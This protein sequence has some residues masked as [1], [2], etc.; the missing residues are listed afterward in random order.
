MKRGPI[1]ALSVTMAMATVATMGRGWIVAARSEPDYRTDVVSAERLELTV[2]ASG[3]VEPQGS[4]EIGTE[5]SGRIQKVNVRPNDRIHVGEV[6]VVM[7]TEQLESRYRESEA[8]VDTARAHVL[9]SDANLL[10][11]EARFARVTR[12]VGMGFV[13]AQELDTA[14][15]TLERSKAGVLIAKAQVKATV[16]QLR[17]AK[18]NLQK[19]TIRSPLDGVV[20]ARNVEPGQTVAAA[21]QTPF[22]LKLA[23]PLSM[24]ELHL[25]VNEA[26]LGGVREGQEAT[27]TVDAFPGKVFHSAVASLHN[28]PKSVQG[29]VVYE[30]IMDAPNEQLELRPGMTATARIKTS[31]LTNV[32]SIS[33]AALRFVPPGRDADDDQ[34]R[35][36]DPRSAAVW[37]L[38]GGQ[39]GLVRVQT[40]ESDGKRTVISPGPLAQGDLV[41][42]AVD[43]PI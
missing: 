39:L 22:L 38:R 15:A 9:E 14:R 8:S 35:G 43:K 10:E 3:T 29:A 5:L 7:D 11:A 20:I 34:P 36:N 13:S 6:L 32:L 4:I 23:Q 16:Q 27:F 33:N 26:D 19:A 37:T 2:S 42:T 17:E 40:G 25:L 21:F 30:A 1:I 31:V 28:T 24:M 12:L 18:T 41:V